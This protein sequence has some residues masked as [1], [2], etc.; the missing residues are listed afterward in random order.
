MKKFFS[1]IL[2]LAM[3]TLLC[4]CG[5]TA[6]APASAPAATP[7]ADSAPA[8]KVYSIGICQLVQHEALDAATLGFRERLTQLL[9]AENVSFNEQNAQGDP[10]LCATVCNQFVAENVDLILANATPALQAAASATGSIPILGT[11]ITDYATALELD[12][13][14]GCT[15]LNISG[16]S[17]LAPL[18]QQADMILELFPEAKTVGILFCSS[19]ANSFFQADKMTELLSAKGISCKNFT[20]TDTNDV[21]SVTAAACD[22]CDALFIPT[23]NSAASN[24]ELI[25]NV[26]VPAGKGV[27]AGEQ[28]LCTGCGVAT[29]SINYYDIGAAAA[30]MAFEILVNGA[31][32][33]T[34][35]ISYAP[36]VEKL[37]NAE[38]CAE[39]GITPPADYTAI[40]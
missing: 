35:E 11:S 22:E 20:F 24:A 19:E 34:M 30:E 16:S 40:G 23:D 37:F 21:A 36:K 18:D 28:G 32:V 10:Q 12:N 15:G 1:L 31:D 9:G 8:A 13:F 38:I 27:V 14:S 5:N 7:A 6:S 29:L 26:C 4:A 3:L 39:L 2:T 17:D 25:R 33:S